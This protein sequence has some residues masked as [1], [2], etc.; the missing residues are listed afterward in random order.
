MKD[1]FF[2]FALLGLHQVSSHR[3]GLSA[4]PLPSRSSC[5]HPEPF[6]SWSLLPAERGIDALGLTCFCIGRIYSINWHFSPSLEL[7]AVSI[8]QREGEKP[9][10]TSVRHFFPYFQLQ[11]CNCWA[12]TTPR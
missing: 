6:L 7:L 9:A 8:R 12:L 11:A 10:A 3:G 4:H 1:F 2:F 5:S